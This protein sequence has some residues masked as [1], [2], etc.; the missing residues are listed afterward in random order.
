MVEKTEKSLNIWI[1][2]QTPKKVPLSSI[3]IREKAKQLH[4]HFTSSS[5]GK[6]AKIRRSS[7][8]KAGLKNSKIGVTFTT[9]N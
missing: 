1:E 3:I 7:Q 9:S 6:L 8:A 4:Q 2:D 5:K